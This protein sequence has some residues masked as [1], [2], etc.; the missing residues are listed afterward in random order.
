MVLRRSLKFG[1]AKITVN[2]KTGDEFRFFALTASA[3]YSDRDKCLKAGIDGFLSKPI[4]AE[5]LRR[6][7]GQYL[8]AEETQRANYRAGSSFLKS[9]GRPVKTNTELVMECM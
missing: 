6:V 9:E 1:D 2:A 5:D 3:M 4:Q 8:R 7:I